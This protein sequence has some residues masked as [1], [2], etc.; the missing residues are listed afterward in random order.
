M[1]YLQPKR[2]RAASKPKNWPPTR[3]WFDFETYSEISLT[4]HGAWAYAEHPSTEVLLTSVAFDDG[5]SVAYEK[6]PE[7]LLCEARDAGAIFCAHNAG[8]EDAIWHKTLKLAPIPSHQ[9]YDTMTHALSVAYP[10]KLDDLGKFVGLDEDKLKLTNGKELI[11][12]FCMPTKGVRHSPEDSPEKWRLF[13][14][15]GER[16][17]D[18]MRDIA[19]KLPQ[20][21]LSE[22]FWKEVRYDI[23][24]NR[25]GVKVDLQLAKRLYQ[26]VEVRGGVVNERLAE[27]T[28]G[29]VTT[30]NQL[31]RIQKELSRLE[32]PN[33]KKETVTEALLL[34]T[35]T[36][37]ER[38][39]LS[40]RQE[41]GLAA[42]KKYSSF[43]NRTSKT[44][45]RLRGFMRLYGARRTGRYNSQGVQLQNL[46]RPSMKWLEIRKWLVKVLDGSEIPTDMIMEVASNCL[47]PTLVA[48]A[49]KMFAISDLAQIEARVLPWLANDYDTLDV[50]RSGRD[51]YIDAA[52]RIYG[53]AYAS[54]TGDQRFVGKTATLALGYGQWVVGF[55]KFCAA[56]GHLI[57]EEE[58]FDIVVPWRDTHQEIVTLW[59][60]TEAAFKHVCE[61][62]QAAQIR[63]RLFVFR[64]GKDVCLRLPSGRHLV[65]PKMFLKHG[66][67]QFY[68]AYGLQDTYGGKL[69]ENA[70]QAAARD[71]MVG[72]LPRI[73]DAGFDVLFTVHDEVI[74]EVPK[75]SID[76]TRVLDELLSFQPEWADGLPLEAEGFLSPRYRK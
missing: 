49:G 16:D 69:V 62:G 41:A 6:F 4:D 67:L 58:A 66:S 29:R 68:G 38:E 73:Q 32:L 17:V 46:V 60:A 57:S 26:L 2:Q 71:V 15:Y 27:L 1:K 30:V 70:T 7:E 54:I 53:S 37:V 18:T 13:K 55:V 43:L 24:M 40:L 19:A 25:R 33:L 47:R 8:F 75:D 56:Y 5:P 9:I 36:T 63:D 59:R 76:D 20:I 22:M 72:N 74:T 28:D 52:A 23:D 61:T 14:L 42:T 34:P 35:L 51:I 50:F 45:E 12:Y 21:N 3:V 39:I 64:D 44:D 11:K 65:Y 48:P 10:A 31:A